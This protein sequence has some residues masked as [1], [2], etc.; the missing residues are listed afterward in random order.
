MHLAV[1][2]LGVGPEPGARPRRPRPDVVGAWLARRRGLL[3]WGA[4]A[5]G[6][7]S[8]LLA[9][10]LSLVVTFALQTLLASAFPG[11]WV[12]RPLPAFLAF[13]LLPLAVTVALGGALGRR[14]GGTGSGPE[15]G[16]AGRCS[17]SFSASRCR[18]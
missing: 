6:A 11:Q 16:S 7:V 13:W 3:T 5:L 8:P 4:V 17:A 1:V 12:A 18:V 15:C 2:A 14:S 10:L 9:F